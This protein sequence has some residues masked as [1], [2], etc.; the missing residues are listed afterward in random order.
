MK[1]KL[2]KNFSESNRV[3]KELE[4]V[5][6]MDGQ[7]KEESNV[8]NPIITIQADNPSHCN[9][10]YIKEFSRYYFI[11]DIKSVRNRIWQLQLEVDPLYTYKDQILKLSCVIDK[12]Q[13]TDFSTELYNDGSFRARE[14][15]FTELKQFP[16]GFNDNGTFVLLVAGA[17]EVQP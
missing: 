9:Y 3:V 4:E 10:C 14:D 7:L 11:K 8:I 13:G 6:D 17:L 2:Y 16:S 5:K 1:I 15:T 12:Q